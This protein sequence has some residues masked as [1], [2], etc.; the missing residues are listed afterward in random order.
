[1]PAQLL[2]GIHYDHE[3]NQPGILQVRSI[4]R[5]VRALTF[6]IQDQAS[7]YHVDIPPTM[8]LRFH[9]GLPLSSTVFRKSSA[10]GPVSL[11]LQ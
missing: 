4:G 8:S 2:P 7:S 6:F 5:Q 10:K 11:K 1:M 3:P 9:A